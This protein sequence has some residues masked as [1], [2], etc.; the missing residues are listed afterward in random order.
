MTISHHADP[1]TL[2]SYAAGSLE[3]PLAAVVAAHA[4]LCPTCSREIRR[5]E[6]I[7]AA[8]IGGLPA[9]PVATRAPTLPELAAL[10]AEQD[11]PDEQEPAARAGG[12]VPAP[13][14]R[15]VG[16]HL[17]DVPWRR[18]SLGVWHLPLPLS[19]GI[20]G[21][22]RLIKVAPGQVMPEHGHGGPELTLMLAGSYRDQLGHYA[23]GDLADLDDAVEHQPVA[24]PET[25]CIC[26][27]AS[28]EKARFKSVLAR[29]IQPF[30]GL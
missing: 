10:E 19:P 13:L 6:R 30:T 16:A 22:L 1:A 18:L 8:L 2:M 15:L 24:D 29:L 4:S 17:D 20:T 26:L 3:E 9:A 23:T 5:L 7:G 28:V 21:D 25:G 14:R 12:D 11:N 27:I